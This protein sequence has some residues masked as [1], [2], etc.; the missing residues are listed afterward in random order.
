MSIQK[1]LDMEQAA[2]DL[3]TKTEDREH[4]QVTITFDPRSH[5]NCFIV[6]D[7]D[8]VGCG[9]TPGAAMDNWVEQQLEYGPRRD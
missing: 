5:L 2:R 1:D 9:S 8:C 3:L 6:V 4:F 7:D